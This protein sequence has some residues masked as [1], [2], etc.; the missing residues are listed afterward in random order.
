MHLIQFALKLCDQ[1]VNTV[2]FTNLF[3]QLLY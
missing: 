3:L 1:T 2:V